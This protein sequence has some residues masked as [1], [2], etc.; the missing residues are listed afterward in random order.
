MRNCPHTSGAIRFSGAL[1]TGEVP[2]S[3]QVYR[4]RRIACRLATGSVRVA[5]QAPGTQVPGLER[6]VLDTSGVRNDCQS[7]EKMVS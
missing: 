6:H 7:G 1:A 5:V 2:S 3:R 4:W